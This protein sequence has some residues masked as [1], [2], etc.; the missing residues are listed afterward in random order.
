MNLNSTEKVLNHI[1][2]ELLDIGEAQSSLKDCLENQ[3]KGH[4]YFD[5]PFRRVFTAQ[6]IDFSSEYSELEQ[7]ELLWKNENSDWIRVLP[8]LQKLWLT[9]DA[10]NLADSESKPSSFVYQMW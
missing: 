8:N 1:F 10:K 3:S 6:D 5:E 4:T 2:D 7:L 9:F